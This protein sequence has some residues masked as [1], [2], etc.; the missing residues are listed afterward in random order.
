MPRRKSASGTTHVG[1]VLPPP[2]AIPVPQKTEAEIAHEREQNAE[3]S[4]LLTKITDCLIQENLDRAVRLAQMAAR[5][6]GP[7]VDFF[8]KVGLQYY[9]LADEGPQRPS[10]KVIWGGAEERRG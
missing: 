2:P 8:E 9:K 7:L 6:Q 4:R 10:F 5:R 1:D 3:I